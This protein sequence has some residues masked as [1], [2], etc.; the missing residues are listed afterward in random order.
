[1][2]RTLPT[3]RFAGAQADDAEALVA[4]RIEAMRDSLE[5]IGRFDPERARARFLDRFSPADTRHIEH[6]GQRVGFV[7]TRVQCDALLLD[8]LC[9]RPASQGKGIGSALILQVIAEADALGLPLRVGALRE[10]EANR[11]YQA[12]GFELVA[13]EEFDNHYLRPMQ[14]T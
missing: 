3:I 5:R 11:F 6:E 10:S 8:H 7:V 12:H 1:M 2:T 13:Q 9:I 4:L 14:K